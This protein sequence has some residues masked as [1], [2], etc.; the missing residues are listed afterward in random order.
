[1]CKLS[2][3][4]SGNK[5]ISKCLIHGDIKVRRVDYKVDNMKG[6]AQWS[7]ERA[8]V[9]E[10]DPF[11]VS[12]GGRTKVKCLLGY[13]L[14]I[15]LFI[16]QVTY[17]TSCCRWDGF[18]RDAEGIWES[19]PRNDLCNMDNTAARHGAVAVLIILFS[20]VI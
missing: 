13:L 5:E 14:F 6:Y 7:L 16:I 8:C 20:I 18:T 19:G 2:K 11:C 9:Q 17:C 15:C 3:V 4:L 12:M 1:M 10:C